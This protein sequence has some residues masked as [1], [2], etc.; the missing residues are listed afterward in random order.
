MEIYK[1]VSEMLL[2][3]FNL[4]K[5]DNL[6]DFQ[7]YYSSTYKFKMHVVN[8]GSYYLYSIMKDTTNLQVTIDKR[9]TISKADSIINT[10]IL[11]LLLTLKGGDT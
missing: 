2:N 10:L 3:E 9:F 7:E 6:P 8:H 4:K 1:M 11:S 5:T